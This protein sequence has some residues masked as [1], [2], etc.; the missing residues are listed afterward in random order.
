MGLPR[1]VRC[2]T[3][4][5][6]LEAIRQKKWLRWADSKAMRKLTDELD[7]GKCALVAS[8]DGSVMRAAIVIVL[9]VKRPGGEVLLEIARIEGGACTISARLPGSK[10]GARETPATTAKK[11]LHTLIRSLGPNAGDPSSFELGACAYVV[12]QTMP[13]PTYGLQTQYHRNIF[14]VSQKT[15]SLIPPPRLNPV[16][17]QLP[18]AKQSKRASL[19]EALSRTSFAVGR[20]S[21]LSTRIRTSTDD[22]MLKAATLRQAVTAE[23]VRPRNSVRS[24]EDSGFYRERDVQTTVSG[25]SLEREGDGVDAGDEDDGVPELIRQHV[26]S[27]AGHWPYHAYIVEDPSGD[28][29]TIYAWVHPDE[30]TMFFDF[31]NLAAVEFDF[32]FARTNTGSTSG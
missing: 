8:K 23:Y 29:Q 9:H 16:V 5:P 6:L 17:P 15:G 24:A 11:V 28:K 18:L 3:Y 20:R 21:H 1:I 4:M 26:P 13:S 7:S 25:Q 27:L 2:R 12:R 32:D 14:N 30:I 19:E 22:T 31:H 10:L